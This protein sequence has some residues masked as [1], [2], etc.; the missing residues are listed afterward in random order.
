MPEGRMDLDIPAYAEM[1]WRGDEETRPGPKRS[2]DMHALARAGVE[3]A[4]TAG[5]DAVSMRTVSAAMGMSSMAL[6]RY[7]K[8]KQELLMM[9]V[10]EAL[11]PPAVQ[12]GEQGWR[13]GMF[14][15]A[16]AARDRLRAHPWVLSVPVAEPA[17]LPYQVQ[18]MELG[19]DV[20][21]ATGLTEPQKLSS[22]LLVN[23]Y[24]R[25]QTQLSLGFE[26]GPVTGVQAGLRFGQ[27]LLSLADP[28]R[29]PRVT[30]AMYAN[31]ADGYQTDFATDEFNFG[32]STV[33]DGI[34]DL[35]ARH[36]DVTVPPR[37]LPRAV[38]RPAWPGPG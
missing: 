38:P 12:A 13:E 10:D 28:D 18:W 8:S 17:I 30:A 25:G 27:R 2:L 36:Q 7:V 24:V 32:L 14:N 19:L 1:L 9:M 4:D 31:P 26:A 23:V 3:L 33:L 21:A 29:Y 16:H 20:L 35:I 6:Y 22:L 34:S 37:P 11:G 15:W 5:L